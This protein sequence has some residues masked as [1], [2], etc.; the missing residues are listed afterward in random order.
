MTTVE[1]ATTYLPRH[2]STTNGTSWTVERLG[3]GVLRLPGE[4]EQDSRLD[5]RFPTKRG[6]RATRLEYQDAMRN[7]K[8]L[9]VLADGAAECWLGRCEDG[10]TLHEQNDQLIK[11]ANRRLSRLSAYHQWSCFDPT[12]SDDLKKENDP[13]Q[14]LPR[15]CKRTR[16][17]G[18]CWTC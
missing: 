3:T 14:V 9:G 11:L 4:N 10:L 2:V 6:R 13:S 18:I 7:G 8:S 1:H 12:R 15:N 16:P 5:N 17:R